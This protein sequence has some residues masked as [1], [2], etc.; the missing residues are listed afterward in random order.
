MRKQN[1]YKSQVVYWNEKDLRIV[2]SNHVNDYR[3]KGRLY[4]PEHISRFDSTLE[5]N[6]YLELCRMYSAARVYRQYPITVV[7]PSYCYPDGR[8]W[9]V[10]FAI[11]NTFHPQKINLLVEAKGLWLPEFSSVLAFLE[12]TNIKAFNRLRIVLGKSCSRGNKVAKALAKSDCK[13]QMLTF[14]Q[15]KKTSRL[16]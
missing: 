12:Q 7:P 2:S 10:D 8:K 16:L 13:H 5:F 9:R 1:K 15:L 14:D 4:L 11:R 6:V 3:K